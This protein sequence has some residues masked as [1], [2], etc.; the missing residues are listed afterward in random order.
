MRKLMHLTRKDKYLVVEDTTFVES[1]YTSGEV[2]R[3]FD[4]N[5]CALDEDSWAFDEDT[6]AFDEDTRAFD[7]E[8]R[9]FHG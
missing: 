8:T 2:P 4:E 6:C 5:A 3:K 7:E 1:T 9:E